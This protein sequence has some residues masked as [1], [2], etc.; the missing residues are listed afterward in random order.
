VELIPHPNGVPR[1]PVSS[2]KHTDFFRNHPNLK[3]KVLNPHLM[4]RK[5]P[6]TPQNTEKLRKMVKIQIKMVF[7]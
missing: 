7:M 1:C 6:A 2:K 3:E 5:V 4:D